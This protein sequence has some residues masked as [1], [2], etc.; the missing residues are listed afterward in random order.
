MYVHLHF[1]PHVHSFYTAIS[2]LWSNDSLRYRMDPHH[3]QIVEVL[4][5]FDGAKAIKYLS[6]CLCKGA[7]MLTAVFQ[8]DGCKAGVLGRKDDVWRRSAVVSKWQNLL[9]GRSVWH[10]LRKCPLLTCERALSAQIAKSNSLKQVLE[11]S[12]I[13]CFSRALGYLSIHFLKGIL[14][15]H[16]YSN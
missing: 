2:H 13:F 8:H 10:S 6:F 4:V 16:F 14:K 3:R 5:I 7:A 1:L 15:R 12:S 11:H 9:H